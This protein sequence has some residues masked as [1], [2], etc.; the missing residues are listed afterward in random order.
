MSSEED[1]EL[2]ENNA[3]PNLSKL[4]RRVLVGI[5]IDEFNSVDVLVFRLSVCHVPS[6][7][8]ETSKRKTFARS[9]GRAGAYP[10]QKHEDP[11]LVRETE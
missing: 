11:G 1:A 10:K 3:C 9:R 6:C 7:M 2:L 5:I 8:V 4:G